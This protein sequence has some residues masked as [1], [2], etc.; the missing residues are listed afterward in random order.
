MFRFGFAATAAALITMAPLQAQA[1][2]NQTLTKTG[3]I[4]RIALPAAAAG[5]SLWKGDYQGLFQFALAYGATIGI[6]EG[7]K[8]VI[9][10]RRP[11]GSDW[12][13]MPSASAASA[14]AASAFLWHRYGWEYGVPAFGLALLTGYSRVQAKKHHWYDVAASD[15]IA[16]SVNYLIVT[17]YH[18]PQ[19]YRFSM[20]ASPDGVSVQFAMNF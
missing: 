19:P 18:E 12:K 3:D 20:G 6:A 4:L 5:I 2:G 8:Q 14:Q 17:R 1:A 10:E 11:D 15:V 9:H 16:F 13:S 7:M